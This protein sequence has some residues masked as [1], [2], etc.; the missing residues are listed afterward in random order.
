MQTPV[1]THSRIEP[2]C[3]YHVIHADKIA[4]VCPLRAQYTSFDLKTDEDTM[5]TVSL[6]FPNIPWLKV[7]TSCRRWPIL[8]SKR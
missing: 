1:T 6:L 8:G 7:L 4:V 5:H 2:P 3:K